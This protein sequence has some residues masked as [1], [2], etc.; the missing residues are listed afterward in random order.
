M[1]DDVLAEESIQKKE[2]AIQKK[3]KAEK[4]N[5]VFTA[6]LLRKMNLAKIFSE[7]RYEM[8]AHK[9]KKR[10]TSV[11]HYHNPG[12]NDHRGITTTH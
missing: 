1:F 10:I 4:V 12:H 9:N 2:K 7:A 3:E 6:Q 8:I 11:T 5:F